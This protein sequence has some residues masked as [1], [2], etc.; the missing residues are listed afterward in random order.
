MNFQE[1]EANF[2]QN[3]FYN[4]D[5]IKI[6]FHTDIIKPIL[7]TVN[8]EMY[9]NYRSEQT[10]LTG[11]RSDATFQNISFEFKKKALFKSNNGID[12]ALYGRNNKDHGLYDY[13]LSNAGLKDNDSEEL[14]IQKI[15]N[16]IGV[17]FDG[18]KFILLVLYLHHKEIRLIQQNLI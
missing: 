4:E 10:F 16:S 5:D 9:N 17:G 14:I 1:I 8:S 12:E 6:H 2:K 3:I 15:V 11:G 7:K 13:I 18:D